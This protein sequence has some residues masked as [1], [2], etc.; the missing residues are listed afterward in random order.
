MYI[1]K[2]VNFYTDANVR[3]T[4]TEVLGALYNQ[5]GPKLQS[6]A[7]SDDMKP[8]VR[9]LLEAVQ[10]NHVIHTFPRNCHSSC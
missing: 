9:S 5:I 3:K 7:F 4:S 2:F 8:I 6:V 10:Y 1:C